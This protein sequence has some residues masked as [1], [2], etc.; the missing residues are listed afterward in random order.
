MLGTARILGGVLLAQGATFNVGGWGMGGDVATLVIGAGI[1]GLSTAFFLRER[2]EDVAVIEAAPRA[3][4]NVMT[5]AHEGYL[6]EAGPNT[7]LDND[8]AI[9]QLIDGL[10]LRALVREARSEAKRRYV[11]R[12]GRAVPLPGSPSTLLT[13]PLFSLEGKLRLLA[14]P[15]IKPANHEESVAEFVRRRLGQEFLDWAIDPFV[16]GVYAGDPERL[17]VRAATAKVYALEHEHGSLLRGALKKAWAARKT[18]VQTGPVGRMLSFERG[19]GQLIDAL[20]VA[21]GEG[22]SLS[23]PAMALRQVDGGWQVDTPQGVFTARRVVLALPAVAV[24]ELL[25]PHVG[26]AVH[27]LREIPY[28]P[29]VSVALG[30]RREDVAHPLDGFGVLIPSKERRTTLGALFS[31]TLFEGRVPEGQVLLTAFIG[32]RRH[33]EV[34]DWDDARVIDRVLDDLGPILGCRASPVMTHISRWP[35]AIP[36]YE[37]GHLQRIAALDTALASLPGLWTRAN[38]RDGVAVSDCIRNAWALAERLAE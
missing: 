29:V 3:G 31:S 20:V 4:G 23:T 35:R 34:G 36:Q 16:S 2:G 27:A 13:T 7:L 26:E 22:L 28:P 21:L 5:L 33:E 37:L 14:E 18:E 15:F 24:A 30:F 8:P 10:G 11:V 6:L 17:S 19:L 1:S 32:G 9:H 25:E 38:W 12:D